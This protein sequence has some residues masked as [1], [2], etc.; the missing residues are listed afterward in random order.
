MVTL[1]AGWSLSET[2]A[3][4]AVSGV[5]CA[6]VVH[7]GASLGH[8]ASPG[9]LA[10]LPGV[11]PRAPAY[12]QHA[13]AVRLHA[14]LAEAI[15]RADWIAVF[16]G[17]GEGGDP[18]PPAPPEPLE[19]LTVLPVL[20]DEP[21]WAGNLAPLLGAETTPD[22]ADFTVLL[23]RGARDIAG[24][25]QVRRDEVAGTGRV[26][27]ETRFVRPGLPEEAVRFSVGVD[28]DART[29]TIGAR[30][31]WLGGS[32]LPQAATLRFPDPL[33]VVPPDAAAT[34]DGLSG[35]IHHVPLQR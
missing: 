2:V 27:Y 31:H 11:F 5:V 10:D 34:V 13:L 6:S 25:V 22:H 19:R 20:G 23:L 29:P 35:F 7:L 16:G 1:H 28:E 8:W 18:P 33:G 17:T 21:R 9:G 3:A 15:A 30:S 14:E 12:A 24:V 32:T 26:N 4:L